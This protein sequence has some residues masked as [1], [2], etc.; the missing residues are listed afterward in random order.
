[1]PKV[2]KETENRQKE[3]FLKSLERGESIIDSA[4]AAGISRV[5][6][7]RWRKS[8]RFKEKVLA[9]I[10]SR[11]QTVEDALYASALKGNIIAIIFWLK[12]RAKDRWKDRFEQKVEVE[13]ELKITDAKKKLIN[14]LDILAAKKKKRRGNK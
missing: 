6:A 14:E 2:T 10:D 5:T 3:A 9:I 1:M 12:N 7:W 13:G 4:K 8:K 11:T